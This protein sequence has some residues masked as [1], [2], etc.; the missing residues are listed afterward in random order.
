MN[1]D[2][3]R[4]SL[5]ALTL[6]AIGVVYGDIGTSPLYTMKE[7]FSPGVGVPLDAPHIVGAVSTIFWALM[8]GGDAEVR[9]ADPARRQPAARAAS[10]R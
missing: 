4:Q 8:F 10:W 9:A 3:R 7:I 6:G 1:E 5:A 2:T